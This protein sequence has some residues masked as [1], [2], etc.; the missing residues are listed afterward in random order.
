MR[1]HL[2]RVRV[3]AVVALALF[4]ACRNPSAAR[5]V[6]QRLLDRPTRTATEQDT[7]RVG[8]DLR[9]TLRLSAPASATFAVAAETA[10]ALAFGVVVRPL[11]ARVTL[12]VWARSG[13]A[14]R[15]MLEEILHA[16][17]PWTDLSVALARGDRA[18]EFEFSG[19]AADV[20]IS[21]PKLLGSGPSRPNV[22]VYLVDCLRADRVGAYG[23]AR[24]VTPSIDRL[25]SQAHVFERAFACAAWTKPSVGCLFTGLDA[26]RHGARTV[27]A[28]LDPQHATLASL[29][30]AAGYTTAAF[31]ANP[32]LEGKDFGYARGFDQYVELAAEWQGKAVNNVDADASKITSAAIPWIELNK[33]R[34][35]FLY[36]HSLDLHYPYRARAG[37]RAARSA[38][39]KGQPARQRPVRQRAACKR[40]GDRTPLGCAFEPP[41][42]TRTP[43]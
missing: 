17:R 20:G 36:L 34:P 5:V 14:R 39:V 42:S 8:G 22:I 2:E 40:R 3:G 27:A 41:A 13:A 32:V 33:D 21:E 1:K 35:F 43:T 18:V 15:L 6:K 4:S 12:R 30:G 29:L 23:Y 37:S 11:T 25:A 31:V 9:R 38:R 19:D 28:A 16:Q 24:G 7:M 26:P 10:D